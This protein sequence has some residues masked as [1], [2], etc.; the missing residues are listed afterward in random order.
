[1]NKLLLIIALLL[2]LSINGHHFFLKALFDSLFLIPVTEMNLTT[3]FVPQMTSI[4]SNIIILGIRTASPIII[5]VFFVRIMIGIMNR[6]VQDADVF[7]VILVLNILI[8]FYI[9]VYYWPYFS[10]MVNI[11]FAMTQNQILIILKLLSQ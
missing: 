2:I 11:V 9:L 1:M 3:D 7:S 8:G 10:Q 5:I 4:A 6:L